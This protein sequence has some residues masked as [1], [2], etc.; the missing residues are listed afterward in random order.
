[1]SLL[2]G[3]TIT[4]PS[5]SK[6]DYSY[7]SFSTPVGVSFTS[8]ITISFLPYASEGLLLY[9]AY[10]SSAT[11]ADFISLAMKGGFLQFRYNLGSGVN[12]TTSSGKLTLGEWY[13]VYASR[14]ERTG[15]QPLS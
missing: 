9:S 8:T 12:V 14:T 10:H 4:I 2:A 13:E 5:F 15:L 7:I 6:T 11:T 1:M 3:E